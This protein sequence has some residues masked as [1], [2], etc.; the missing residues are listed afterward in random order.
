[1]K[2]KQVNVTHLCMDNADENKLLEKRLRSKDWKHDIEVEYTAR[3]RPQQNSI[4]EVGFFTIMNW[5]C[6][7]MHQAHI[8]IKERH[9]IWKEAVKTAT[10]LD[11]LVMVNNE[12]GEKKTSF[13][14]LNK[15]LTKFA[16][17][18]RTWGEAGTVKIKTGSSTKIQDRGVHC[19][20]VGYSTDHPGDCYR[21]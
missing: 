9:K 13:E 1:M 16:S 19:V 5:T 14:H 15:K 21:M 8:P 4:A 3:D 11:G 2:N 7:M 10:L 20:F 12:K 18:L 17:N 6:A